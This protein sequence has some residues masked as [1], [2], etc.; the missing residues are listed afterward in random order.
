M[1]AKRKSQCMLK[2]CQQQMLTSI[3]RKNNNHSNYLLFVK[4]CSN[5][6]TRASIRMATHQLQSN[7]PV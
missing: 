7:H 1:R 3:V 4:V 6:F 5:G 2:E